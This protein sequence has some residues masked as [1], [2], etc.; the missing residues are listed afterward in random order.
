MTGRVLVAVGL[1]SAYLAAGAVASVSCSHQAAA[2][3]LLHQRRSKICS[4]VLH[5]VAAVVVVA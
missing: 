1:A 5:S 3:R 2:A 4:A